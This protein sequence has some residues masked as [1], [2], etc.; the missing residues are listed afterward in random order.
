MHPPVPLV[1]QAY[2]AH[3]H[4]HGK[5]LLLSTVA[6]GMVLSPGQPQDFL[7]KLI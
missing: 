6:L 7:K 1:L 3:R 5:S 2:L 4:H